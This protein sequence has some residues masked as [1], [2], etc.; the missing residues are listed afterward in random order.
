MVGVETSRGFI[1]AKKVGVVTAGHSSVMARGGTHQ[2]WAPTFDHFAD[3]YL[4]ALHRMGLS[5]AS[6]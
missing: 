4:P 3:S 6:G 1:G 2:E 5:A